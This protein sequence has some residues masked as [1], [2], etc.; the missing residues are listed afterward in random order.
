MIFSPGVGLKTTGQQLHSW[1]GRSDEIVSVVF[2][3]P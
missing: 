2:E 1:S 3:D